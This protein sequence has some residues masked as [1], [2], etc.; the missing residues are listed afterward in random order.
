[1]MPDNALR[2]R[3]HPKCQAEQFAARA[4][5]INTP[6]VARII[7]HGVNRQRIARRKHLPVKFLARRH[8]V[9]TADRLVELARIPRFIFVTDRE[10][11]I[12]AIV[13]I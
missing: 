8:A 9:G 12:A 13:L 7:Q 3:D 4:T 5:S 6:A 1:M 10:I 2:Q 11:A